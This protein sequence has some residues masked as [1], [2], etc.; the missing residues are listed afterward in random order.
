MPWLLCTVSLCCLLAR[1]Q[2]STVILRSVPIARLLNQRASSP[3][4]LHIG[5]AA[6]LL[7]DCGIFLFGVGVYS[8]LQHIVFAIFVPSIN[9][10]K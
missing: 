3:F 7:S 5:F 9:R 10:H 1:K 6:R 4:I 2:I 8:F